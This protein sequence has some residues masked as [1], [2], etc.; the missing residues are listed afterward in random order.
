VSKA[1]AAREDGARSRLS[2]VVRC[3]EDTA[4]LGKYDAPRRRRLGRATTERRMSVNAEREQRGKREG[5]RHS[6]W[7]GASPA[8]QAY[9][10]T[11]DTQLSSSPLLP[12]LPL[13]LFFRETRVLRTRA[14]QQCYRPTCASPPFQGTHPGVS[15][16]VRRLSGHRPP[17][18]REPENCPNWSVRDLS[19]GREDQQKLSA[20]PGT[21]WAKVRGCSGQIG[22]CAQASRNCVAS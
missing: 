5:W 9:V 16:L 22:T 6:C 12:R 4:S 11:D 15:T 17:D 13:L 18:R 10:V 14:I 20:N 19:D 7:L 1:I 21:K 3:I 2:R 8:T